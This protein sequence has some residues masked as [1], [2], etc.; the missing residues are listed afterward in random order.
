MVTEHSGAACWGCVFRQIGRALWWLFRLFLVA[1][2]VQGFAILATD[3]TVGLTKPPPPSILVLM[4]LTALFGIA[5]GSI[6]EHGRG[7]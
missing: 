7:E 4:T 6:W 3:M 5:A 2:V 1:A